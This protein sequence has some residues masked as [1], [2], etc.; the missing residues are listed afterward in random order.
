LQNKFFLT[1]FVILFLF[2]IF[3]LGESYADPNGQFEGSSSSSTTYELPPLEDNNPRVYQSFSG[4][5]I[6]GDFNF[7]NESNNIVITPVGIWSTECFQT[8]TDPFAF[9]YSK[10]FTVDADMNKDKVNIDLKFNDPEPGKLSLTVLVYDPNDPGAVCGSR[11]QYVD[12]EIIDQRL[13][14]HIQN[15]SF[16]INENGDISSTGNDVNTITG[17]WRS[18]NPFDFTTYLSAESQQSW[19]LQIEK[20]HPPIAVITPT[21]DIVVNSAENV[22][23]SGTNSFDPDLTDDVDRYRWTDPLGLSEEEELNSPIISFDYPSEFPPDSLTFSL[24]VFDTRGEGSNLANKEIFLNHPPTPEINVLPSNTVDENT[25]VTLDASQSNANGPFDDKIIKYSWSQPSGPPVTLNPLDPLSSSVQFKAP[26]IDENEDE[27]ILEFSL[28]VQDKYGAETLQPVFIKVENV[29]R[30]PNPIIDVIPTNIVKPGKTVIL[31]GSRSNDPDP[32]DEIISYEWKQ[33]EGPP[34]DLL[35][36]I[37]TSQLSGSLNK[38]VQFQTPEVLE[39]TV[40]TFSLSLT[41]K[42]G[43]SASAIASITVQLNTPPIAI[44]KSFPDKIAAPEETVSLLGF[45]SF[46]PDPG[47]FIPDDS[48]L[49]T[50]TDTTPFRANIMNPNNA[51][52]SFD[53]P[54]ALD[55][56]PENNKLQFSLTVKDSHGLESLPVSLPITIDCGI[57]DKETAARTLETANII[58]TGGEFIPPFGIFPQ[59]S[60]N[61]QYW[62]DGSGLHK[63]L[64]LLWLDNQI[65]FIDAQQSIAKNII[66]DVKNELKLMNIG[67][68]KEFKK[69]YPYDI[70]NPTKGLIPT[71]KDFAFA[72]G[73]ANIFANVDLVINNNRFSDSLSGSITFTLKDIYNFNPGDIFNIP[74][75]GKVLADDLNILEKCNFAKPFDQETRFSKIVSEI[76]IDAYDDVLVSCQV[77]TPT[78]RIV[79]VP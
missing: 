17:P 60:A 74:G 41:D 50:Q 24:L 20:N 57:A 22:Q 42:Q 30:P 62:L 37:S 54:K 25:T 39:D 26:N 40:M 21:T 63:E 27:I 78:C 2:A 73:R 15:P 75:I 71:Q 23:L 9:Q 52:A 44:A 45:D 43:N 53:T 51:I 59:S 68:S 19:D 61:M 16:N 79:D 72:V 14:I 4:S 7:R 28:I 29:N 34:V 69:G 70:T 5:S 13:I 8:S 32:D 49:W 12:A 36:V 65:N 56:N 6:I 35:P 3:T 38:K 48:Y 58:I 55:R 66:K 77:S 64:P 18:G 11:P 1:L 33:I 46:D 31:D 67:E 10:K 47:D 76:S